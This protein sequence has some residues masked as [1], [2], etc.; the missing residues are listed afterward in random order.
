MNVIGLEVSTS[1]AKCILFSLEEGI[2]ESA[3]VNYSKEVSD[4][5][6]QDPEGIFTAALE[7]LTKVVKSTDRKISA[8]GL[9]GTWH[10]LLLL[11]KER[12]PL[13]RIRTWA[14][15]SAAPS[16]DGLREDRNF[17]DRF[18]Q[19]TGCMVHGLYPIWKFHHLK[20]TRPELAGKTVYLGS[21]IEYLFLRLT[22]K[23]Y[24]SK[25]IASGTGFFNIHSLDWDD[26][27]LEL[28][29]VRREQF[30]ELKEAP[31]SAPLLREIAG[32]VGL[33]SGVPVTVGCADGALNQA[34]IGGAKE[35]MMSF[36]VGTSAAIRM[37]CNEPV[38]PAVPSTWCYYLYNGKRLA[39]A[40]TQGSTNCL[41]WYLDCLVPGG[42]KAHDYKKYD[43]AAAGVELS[44]AP[45]FLP[46]LFGER[47]PGWQEERR[48]GFLD[49]KATHNEGDL[50]YAV[51]EGILFNI[52]QCYRILTEVGGEPEEI[53]ISGGIM[54]SP[55]WLQLA[56]DIFGRELGTT[57][58]TNDSTVGAALF[59]LQAMGGIERIEDYRPPVTDRV[60]PQPGR[61]DLL[62]KRFD[63]YLKFYEA[64]LI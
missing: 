33:P 38:I 26:E 35:G 19:K 31:E 56:A 46:F 18:Y 47:C 3:S 32:K 16:V 25:C 22:G 44:D 64:T 51:L 12:R 34:G 36:S 30:G 20:K 54:N 9:G 41:G 48:G 17:V 50:Y 57:G 52:Y 14:D 60:T 61:V 28:T 58:F 5:V 29:G 55:F 24:V 8:I 7:A 10:S 13:D 37:V 42:P 59:A 39:G 4:T 49:V 53:R 43:Q 40:A 2:I 27:L 1:A 23:N 11:D 63:K 15:V 6:S 62:R 21:Q 45:Y